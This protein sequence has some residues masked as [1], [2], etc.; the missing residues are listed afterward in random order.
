MKVWAKTT[1][2]SEGK[3]L[4]VRR[5]GTTP[6][7]PHFVMGARDPAAPMGLLEYAKS[8]EQGGFD[9]EYIASVR[10]LSANFLQYRA[11]HGDGDPD[12]PPHRKDLPLAIGMMRHQLSVADIAAALEKIER[13]AAASEGGALPR[14]QALARLLLDGRKPPHLP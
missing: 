6:D 3:F 13:L 2:F 14:I 10:E 11:A 5:D 12:A 8:G 9:P 1:E 4:V 7:W